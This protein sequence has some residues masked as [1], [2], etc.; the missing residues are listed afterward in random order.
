M[1]SSPAARK[2][3]HRRWLQ[4]GL[5]TFLIAVVVVALGMGWLRWQIQQAQRRD[6]AVNK[7]ARL[8][9]A[10]GYAHEL[11]P[12][13]YLVAHPEPPGPDW[14]NQLLGVNLRLRP[15]VL[16]VLAR[17]EDI[18]DSLRQAG[19]HLAL[20]PTVETVHMSDVR[21]S[22]QGMASLA[23]LQ[24]LKTLN[25]VTCMFPEQA[26]EELA[27]C[28]RLESLSLGRL[29]AADGGGPAAETIT[30]AGV[31]NL[32]GLK[33]LR[34]LDLSNTEVSD[35]GLAVIAQLP[36]LETLQLAGT[37][38]TDEGVA[39]LAGLKHLRELNLAFNEGISDKSVASL[40]GLNLRVLN[41]YGTQLGDAG[42]LGLCDMSQ[43]ESLYINGTQVSPAAAAAFQRDHPHIAV[44]YAAPSVFQPGSFSPG[45]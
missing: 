12:D 32:A 40:S 42:L 24:G 41:L 33:Q 37:K 18:D 35:Q 27:G 30:D 43:L 31:A 26:L 34:E 3:N 38:I 28:E 25:L 6:A 21:F 9:G 13:G 14:L 10:I 8:L 16:N 19:E 2:P 23:R 36:R 22:R 20:L 1:S 11:T 15:R 4:F 7:V 29:P 44:Q 45:R 39:Q 5:R 17:H